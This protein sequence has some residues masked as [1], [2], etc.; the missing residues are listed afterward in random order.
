LKNK[1]VLH[2]VRL[3]IALGRVARDDFQTF[4][5][6]KKER[7]GKKASDFCYGI[8]VICLLQLVIA[9]VNKPT[10][11]SCAF[12]VTDVVNASVSI[13]PS[14]LTYIKIVQKIRLTFL[15]L[16]CTNPFLLFINAV[17]CALI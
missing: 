7:I 9:F 4:A 10:Q 12:V 6:I 14:L 2:D 17:H 1:T 8:L 3:R 16:I 13:T 5:F 11:A 15:I